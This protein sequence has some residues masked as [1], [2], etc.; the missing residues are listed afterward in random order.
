MR[1]LA[2]IVV[3]SLVSRILFAATL[4]VVIEVRPSEADSRITRF[5]EP[6]YVTY[7]RDVGAGAPVTVFLPGTEGQPRNARMLLDVV[8]DQGFR[9]IG[10][11]YND[12]PS[13]IEVCGRRLSSDCSESFR[14]RRIFGS[15]GNV[16]IDDRPWESIANRLASLLTYLNEHDSKAWGGYLVDGKPDWG[17]LVVS[18]F[19]QGAGMAA[20]IA[21]TEKL[22]RV[23]LFSGPGDSTGPSHQ[24]VPWLY[25]SGA[26]PPSRWF[27]EYHR[28]E[29][30]S[31]VIANAYRVL[32]IPDSN[33]LVFDL[34]FPEGFGIYRL[35]PFHQSTIQLPAYTEQWRSLFGRVDSAA[36][37]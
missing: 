35:D 15:G 31:A 30:N 20:Y 36:T 4:H 5:N 26:T 23:V 24:P 11:E 22:R 9:V 18:G 25:R 32:E 14:A 6:N 37:R 12:T 16:D 13:V 8:A 33:V 7:R 34:G 19:S 21:K 1:Y 29:R 28:H 10:L 17:H 2:A 27:A 3:A